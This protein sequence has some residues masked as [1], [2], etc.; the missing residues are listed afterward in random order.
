MSQGDNTE[1]GAGRLLAGRYRLVS[2]VGTGGMGTVWRARDETL[3]RDVA[4]KEV[5]VHTSVSDEE[6]RERHVRTL[7]EARA[8]ARLN[9]PGVVT[10]H[11]VVDEDDRPWIVM[12]LLRA[13]SLQDLVDEDGPL[14]PARAAG[15][16]RQIAS[17]LRAAHAV[18]ILHRD[19]KPA[20]VLVADDDRAVLTDFGIA[21]VVGDATLTKTG[22]LVGSPAYMA[23]ER[24][25]GERAVP[26]SDLWALGATL[27]TACEGRPPHHRADAMAVLAAI[28]T[29]EPPPPRNAGPLTPVLLGLLERDLGR[30]M[31][32]EQAEPLLA[33][34]AAG[35]TAVDVPARPAPSPV[36]APHVS[37]QSAPV[38]PVHTPDGTAQNAAAF[39]P[40]GGQVWSPNDIATTSPS[41]G[42]TERTGRSDRHLVLMTVG[43]MI[44]VTAIAI[45]VTVALWPDR[46]SGADP[47]VTR[48]ALADV[49]TGR[50]A[51]SE[52]A[53]Q[54]QTPGTAGATP[55]RSEASTPAA[56]PGFHTASGPG[57]TIAVP[58]GWV[59]SA[60]GA[61]VFWRD[62]A[63]GA[64]VQVDRTPWTGDPTEHW[65]QWESEVLAKNALPGYTR[66]DLRTTSVDGY[67]AAD[68]EFAFS[69]RGGTR[70]VDRGVRVGGSSYAVFVAVPAS[71]W[72]D[73]QETVNNVL[74]TFR[75]TAVR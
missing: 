67:P 6:R 40:D 25:R 26:A 50:V 74:D 17:A 13:R 72:N 16:G 31:T 2:V 8:S 57:Y 3:H 59:R 45:A 63:T 1:A 47:Q 62:P 68:L 44:A 30:R 29:E 24:L 38:P 61:S 46:G 15:I 22:L 43:A 73:Y 33:Q 11:D 23:P 27:Y 14:P 70:A 41:G 48:S 53:A 60:R 42:E 12:E 75:P 66:L 4:V 71:R 19:I 28:M 32:A 69:A 9:H 21:H 7:R 58:A 56:P 18:G 54:T 34:I 64:Y 10:V 52:S 36:A 49:P 20:N 51:T 5:V 35:S 37:T 39:L 65:M 55:T